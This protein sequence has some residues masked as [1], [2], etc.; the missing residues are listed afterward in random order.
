MESFL[1]SIIET[2]DLTKNIVTKWFAKGIGMVKMHLYIQGGFLGF[3]RNV[4]GYG[5]IDFELTGISKIDDVSSNS[6]VIDTR[7]K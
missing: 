7:S 2:S 5:K 1:R 4:M 3:V 6:G